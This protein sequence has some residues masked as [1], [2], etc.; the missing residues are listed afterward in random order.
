MCISESVEMRVKNFGQLSGQPISLLKSYF[1]GAVNFYLKK[2][3]RSGVEDNEQNDKEKK[4]LIYLQ[5]KYQGRK[6]VYSFGQSVEPK[7][8]SFSK[9]RVKN[10]K[11]TTADGDH[12]LNELLESLKSICEISYKQE[13]KNG[14]P[15]P[16][17]IKGH[18]D[19]FMNQNEKADPSRSLYALIDR[20]ISGQIKSRG[21]EK[22]PATLNN[23]Q[24]VKLHLQNFEKAK[25]YPVSFETIS[26]DFFYKYT[27]YLS[28]EHDPRLSPN[29]IAKDIR[30]L[31]VFL[32]EG[33]DLGWSTNHQF[34][35]KKFFVEGTETDAVYLSE[36]EILKLYRH[37]FSF[38]SKLEQTR[39]LFVFG[40]FVGL[41]FSDYNNVK[42]ENII[43]HD[44]ELFV[45]LRTAKTGEQ[46]IIPCNPIVL[47]IFEKY[48]HNPNKLPKSL[49]NQ[50]FNDYIKEVCEKAEMKEIG[51]LSTNPQ[52]PLFECISSHT[53]R[54]S[55]ATN[56][57]LAGFPTIDLM[58]ITG[59]RTEKAF[60]KYIRITK[61]DTAKRLSAHIKKNWSEMLLRVA[62]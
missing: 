26:L 8:W 59:H 3:P 10:N 41:R 39:D 24:A 60:L 11:Q 7:N 46:V 43:D 4:Q 6:L 32:A 12:L 23:Y 9:Q 37:D 62:G 58:K 30:I 33:I 16:A 56:L 40:C 14:I 36:K 29:T 19:R 17:T 45:K 34:R 20:F 54:R 49:S 53:A 48:N 35:N 15:L 5:F 2:P 25:K 38:N 21:R 1:M 52:K 47:E 55:F 42:P 13:L 28:R 61:L 22:S 50:K 31:K 18:L 57:Y 44:G 27:D 51:R